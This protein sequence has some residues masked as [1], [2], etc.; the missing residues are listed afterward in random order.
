MDG[1][2]VSFDRERKDIDEVAMTHMQFQAL[3]MLI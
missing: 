1:Y 2:N 3:R